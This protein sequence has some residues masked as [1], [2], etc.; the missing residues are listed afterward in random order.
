MKDKVLFENNKFWLLENVPE[1]P[2]ENDF[3]RHRSPGFNDFIKADSDYL[4][5][6]KACIA[7]KKEID[8]RDV[9]E[10]WLTMRKGYFECI[11]L[12]DGDI[13][14][15]PD[16]M[17]FEEKCK[18]CCYKTELLGC[19]FGKCEKVIHLKLKQDVKEGVVIIPNHFSKR[20]AIISRAMTYL[21]E[22]DGIGKEIFD[23]L[24]TLLEV[25]EES[26]DALKSQTLKR[27]HMIIAPAIG[28][29]RIGLRTGNT[30]AYSHKMF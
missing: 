6:L 27:W 7:A 17:E 5:A 2:N 29:I 30:L 9:F 23:D 20:N 14:P 3:K 10:N 11:E 24:S 1:E 13:F 12:K 25:R 8:N 19:K 15:I 16:N 18:Y 21:S 28:L 22:E 26:Q 4:K